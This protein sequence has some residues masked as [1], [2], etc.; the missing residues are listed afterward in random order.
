VAAPATRPV[1]IA[2]RLTLIPASF[3]MAQDDAALMFISMGRR[4]EA[5]KYSDL[6]QTR[7]AILA[8]PR[9]L[10]RLMHLAERE[11]L[12][13][14]ADAAFAIAQRALE[15]A[16]GN[17]RQTAVAESTL[18]F[19]YAWTGNKDRA[20]AEYTRLLRVPFSRLNIH[21]MKHDPRHAPL[22]DDPRFQALLADPKNNAPL[23]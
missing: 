15:N 16:K 7:T 17:A 5:L 14:S 19:L 6:E 13:G 4:A 9:S 11:A 12:F 8:A 23:F 2:G 21:E 10:G 18:A 3:L 20:I 22:R 1:T